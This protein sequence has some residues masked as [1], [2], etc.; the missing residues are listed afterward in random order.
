MIPG[1]IHGGKTGHIYVHDR[2]NC[3]LIRFSEAMIPQ[4]NMW[5]L[6][7]AQ[8]ARVLPGANGGG[9]WAPMA[10]NPK[11]RLAYARDLAQPLTYH[12]EAAHYPGR[13]KLWLV[14]AVHALSH[15]Y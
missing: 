2:S 8:G 14:A 9:G 7:T 12:V 4:E 3:N 10:F 1:V 15:E 5:V 13:T 6:P 11:T